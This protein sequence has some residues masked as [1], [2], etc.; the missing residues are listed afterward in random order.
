[1][2]EITCSLC[3][4]PDSVPIADV[5]DRLLGID[6]QFKMVRCSR[7]G[8]HYLNPQPTM[9]DLVP[10]YP[11]SYAPFEIPSPDQLPLLRRLS[12]N[13]GLRKR[14]RAVMRYKR[15][16]RLLEIGCANGLFL[17][18]MRR[19]GSWQLQG[20]DTSESAVRYARERLSLEV[21]HGPLEDAGFPNRHFD[22]VVMWDVLE[23]VHQPRET[24]IE[25][26]RILKPDGVLVF[27]VPLLDSWDRKLFGPYWAG[28]DAPRH[29]TVFSRRTL[30]MML[31]RT[32]FR[33]ARTDCVSGSY[34]AFVLSVRFWARQRLSVPA[35][36]RLNRV[37]E[38]LPVRLVVA[39][40][41]YVVDRLG[42]S[43]VVT[44]VAQP[45]GEG[46]SLDMTED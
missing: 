40:C 18:A 46:D 4:S 21:F 42:K 39:P 16:G 11:E 23:H 10:Y 36:E 30:D 20:V 43:T 27:R 26:R 1:M 22:A 31:A 15:S 35:Q 12:V 33:V 3:D 29:L 17:D 28:W 34:P 44:I 14:R 41:F 13:Y 9:S 32:D 37:L 19:M 8:L 45:G 6:G 24:L 2:H 5:H 38:S 7:C 25:I